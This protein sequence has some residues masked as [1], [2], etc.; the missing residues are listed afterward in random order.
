[1][2]VV[3][4]WADIEGQIVAVKPNPL[5]D[6]FVTAQIKVANVVP[7][8]GFPNLFEQAKGSIIEVNIP[9]SKAKELSL[10]AGKAISGRIRKGGPTT[11]FVHPDFLKTR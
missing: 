5:M 8:P 6:N 1:M 2:Q 3:E 9:A 10:S 4:N 7:V 11:A